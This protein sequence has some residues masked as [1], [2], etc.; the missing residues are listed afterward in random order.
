MEALSLSPLCLLYCFS[1]PVPQV[2]LS[3]FIEAS[4][5]CSFLLAR[6][7]ITFIPRKGSHFQRLVQPKFYPKL[8]L[9]FVYFQIGKSREKPRTPFKNVYFEMSGELLSE[10]LGS[11]NAKIKTVLT[12]RLVGG[13][14]QGSHLS[15]A[16]S[17][18]SKAP[19]TGVGALFYLELLII[20]G[21]MTIAQ[22]A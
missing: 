21:L 6:R 7:K 19:E 2:S 10:S 14:C 9:S 12:G 8:L 18:A 1:I 11:H 5:P 16:I 4:M 22:T 20:C 15:R 3:L 13:T 17:R